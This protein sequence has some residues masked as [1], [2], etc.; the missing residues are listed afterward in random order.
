VFVSISGRWEKEE[1]DG[2]ADRGSKEGSLP[3]ARVAELCRHECLEEREEIPGRW[4][5]A[6]AGRSSDRN[7]GCLKRFSIDDKPGDSTHDGRTTV[8]TGREERH[9]R[10][11]QRL[12]CRCAPWGVTMARGAE[13]CAGNGRQSRYPVG[14]KQRF[15]TGPRHADISRSDLSQSL[16][17]TRGVLEEELDGTVAYKAADAV[18][19]KAGKAKNG[20]GA[21]TRYGL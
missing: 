15:P 8:H 19:P 14:L 20:K 4:G 16:F 7:R 5:L 9:G 13:A 1:Q 11:R 2:S 10:G 21:N 17:Q 3:A 12:R 18:T 6:A